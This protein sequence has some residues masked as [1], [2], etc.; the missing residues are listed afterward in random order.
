[1]AA[2]RMVP[3]SFAVALDIDAQLV[4]QLPVLTDLAQGNTYAV[5]LA[6]LYRGFIVLKEDHYPRDSWNF[7]FAQIM[8]LAQAATLS[9][10]PA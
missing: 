10:P 6:L 9:T 2:E 1:M 8:D 7:L 4:Q 3:S 5:A